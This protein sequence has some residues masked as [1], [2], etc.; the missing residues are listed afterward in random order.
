M[1]TVKEELQRK[2][3]ALAQTIQS[4]MDPRGAAERGELSKENDR[5][6]ML[7]EPVTY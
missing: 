6:P 7:L 4:S 1:D 2:R 5:A 3:R